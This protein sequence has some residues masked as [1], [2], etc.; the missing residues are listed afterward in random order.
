MSVITIS[1]ETGSDGDKLGMELAEELDYLFLDKEIIRQVAE[2]IGTSPEA[3]ERYDEKAE[4]RLVRFLSG[5]FR[6][7]PEMVPYYGT[8]PQSEPAFAYGVSVPYLYYETPEGAGAPPPDPEKLVE[9]F[10]D[11]IKKCAGEGNAVIVGRGSQCILREAPGVIHIRTVAPLDWRVQNMLRDN[12]DLEEDD[13]R[14]LAERN[15]CWRKNYISAHY[16]VDWDDPALYH[17]T[18]SMDRW[19]RRALVRVLK[20][21][22]E[23]QGT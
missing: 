8:F 16:D 5:I 15:D 22:A 7:H 2:E 9:H 3:V 10:R 17:L 23:K 1:R 21:A 6:S 20:S 13:A 11:I 12:P 4:G 18:V 19:D 14:A